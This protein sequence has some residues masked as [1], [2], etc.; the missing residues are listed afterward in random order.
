MVTNISGDNVFF[1]SD[2][3]FGHLNILKFCN[4]PWDNIDKHDADLINNWNS[5]VGIDDT[6]FH[7]GD[8]CKG[9]SDKWKSIRS[10]LNGHIYLI[11]GNHDKM[12]QPM[13]DLFDGVFQQLQLKIDKRTVYLNHFPFLCFSHSDPKLYHDGYAI[14]LFG[15][16]HSSP[17]DLN[18]PEHSDD[19]RLKYLYPTQYDVGVDNNEYY[20]IS[21]EK[22]YNIIQK[23]IE[24]SKQ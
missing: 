6:V 7:L 15:H 21:W 19:G 22:V 11:R 3:H 16:V 8:F 9:G 14:N 2:T 20:P 4:R 10:Q 5:V 24:K 18:A 1:T 12:S 13:M 17:K 23:Q